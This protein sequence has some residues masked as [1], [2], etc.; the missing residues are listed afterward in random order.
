[1]RNQNLELKKNKNPAKIMNGKFDNND[2]NIFKLQQK[3]NC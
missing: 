1:M 2:G 3:S